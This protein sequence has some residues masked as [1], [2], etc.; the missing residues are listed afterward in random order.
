MNVDA[1]GSAQGAG[2]DPLLTVVVTVVAG[3]EP[4]RRCLAAVTTQHD[5]PPL[6]I[7]VPL[8]AS[9]AELRSLGEEFAAVSWLELGPVET[10]APIASAAGQHELYDRRRAAA[11]AV[12]RGDLVAIIEDRGVP[13]PD[14]AR[15]AVRLHRG[16]AA[17]IGGAIEPAPAGLV[18]WALHVCDFSRYALPLTSGP[19]AWVSDVNVT[20]KRRALERTREIWRERFHEPLVH[21]H[22]LRDGD[23]LRLDPALVVDHH[24]TARPFGALL[25]ERFAWGRL[26][27]AIHAS[28]LSR[29]RRALLVAAAPV[30]PLLLLARHGRVWFRRGEG[31]RYLRAVPVLLA[32][33]TAWA[34]GEAAGL[35]T[36]RSTRR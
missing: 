29:S 8:D 26:F 19:A 3:R 13:R 35:F 34:A 17:V 36:A 27:G 31:G 23:E 32:L 7:L 10:T 30:V 15:T 11:L 18:A 14:W 21:W 1:A 12:A 20:Y 24:R 22:L 25:G 28:T 6:E 5:P 2:P 16:P 9:V 33:L 4:L